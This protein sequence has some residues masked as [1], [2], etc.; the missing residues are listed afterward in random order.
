MYQL[1]KSLLFKIDPEKCH[2][3]AIDGMAFLSWC[4]ENNIIPIK[5]NT[6]NNKS[7]N[8][9]NFPNPVGLS[10]GFDK[11]AE[12]IL[13]LQNMGFGFIEIGTVT[14]FP[15]KGNNI[16]P[17]IK[18]DCINYTLFNN[19]GMPSDGVDII[20]K[21]IVSLKEKDLIKIPLGI[22]IGDKIGNNTKECIENTNYVLKELQEFADFIVVN[23]SCPN[24]KRN[25]NY[26]DYIC[27]IS[28]NNQ[29]LKFTKPIYLKLSLLN[30]EY[31]I[32]KK[33]NIAI[34]NG[35][36]G[37]IIGNTYPYKMGGI[38][39][40]KIFNLSTSIL[41]NIKQLYPKCTIIGSGGIIEKHHAR[42]K[43]ENGSDL[44]QIYTGLIYN[45]PKLID[46]IIEE[47]KKYEL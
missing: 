41:K 14:K 16:Y 19:L 1:L 44:I 10:A 9:I 5:I 6:Q 3:I 28:E 38:S 21:R 13:A 30:S 37:F 12:C 42:I 17:R 31:N 47:L 11:N 39:G 36:D 20:K 26:Y 35:Y 2:S 22:N 15:N 43:I 45:G 27:K 7:I 25:F 23:I 33:T 8:N 34:K 46:D 24:V 32:E 40:L 18:R 29:N 4:I